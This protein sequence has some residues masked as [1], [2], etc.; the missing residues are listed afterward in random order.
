M[1]L[2]NAPKQWKII[3]TKKAYSSFFIDLYEDTL[4]ID[5]KNK[6]YIRG[7][8]KDYSTIVPFMSNDEILAIKSYRY[9]VDS[10]QIE[11]PSG[12][13]DEGE[14]A[15]QAALRELKEETGYSARKLIPIGTYTTDYSM[16]KQKG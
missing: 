11:V 1:L 3:S 2:N 10:F 12:Y 4:D 5:G 8:R 14:S 13:I 16:F 15:Q 6:I 9:L 7:I